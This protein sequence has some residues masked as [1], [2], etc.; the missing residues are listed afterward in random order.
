MNNDDAS[1]FQVIRSS[2]RSNPKQIMQSIKTE[3]PGASKQQIESAI[4]YIY[5][6]A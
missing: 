2:N 4:K 1:R 5:D 6:R 3:L